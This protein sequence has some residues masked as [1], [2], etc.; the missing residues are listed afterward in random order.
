MNTT[1][2]DIVA[3]R[4]Y[5]LKTCLLPGVGTLN[6]VTEPAEADFINSSILSPRQRIVFE[7]S[8]NGVSGNELS[9]FAHQ[10]H[11]E[12]EQNAEVLLPGIGKLSKTGNGDITFEAESVPDSF[13]PS[14]HT[15][16]VIRQDATH[17][18]LVGDKETTNVVMTE[19]FNETVSNKE[20]WWIWAAALAVVGI[21]ILAWY[22]YVY[23]FNN[24]GNI[25]PLG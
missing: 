4:L 10:L 15:V 9:A 14:V 25:S 13:Y 21:A 19:Y 6:L 17:Q 5:N 1:D 11:H 18:I 24:L 23:G 16:R 7:G 12:L 2:L 22:F 20:K 3:H 8:Q